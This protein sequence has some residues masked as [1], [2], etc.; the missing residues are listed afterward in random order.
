MTLIIRLFG[1]RMSNL[2]VVQGKCAD[3]RRRAGTTCCSNPRSPDEAMFRD[4][5][6]DL[7]GVNQA[8]SV[9]WKMLH[10]YA[11]SKSGENPLV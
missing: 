10:A 4:G 6:F 3:H 7:W 8:F 2:Q 5:N 11:L 1:S 9:E